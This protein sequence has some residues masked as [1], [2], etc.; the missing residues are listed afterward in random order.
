MRCRG[1]GG[2][3]GACPLGVYVISFY[4][5]ISL[6]YG[7]CPV[8]LFYECDKLDILLH[9]FF[10]FYIEPLIVNLNCPMKDK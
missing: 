7:L 10:S 2:V 3:T 4:A 5:F 9:T 8:Y 6:N 1:G